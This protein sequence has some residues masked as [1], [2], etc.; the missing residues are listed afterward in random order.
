MFLCTLS[1]E[2]EE[3]EEDD[4]DTDYLIFFSYIRK[5]IIIIINGIFSV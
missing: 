5:W 4:V 1:I 3:E 2:E